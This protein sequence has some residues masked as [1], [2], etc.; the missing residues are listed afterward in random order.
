M[1][2][3]F[4]NTKIFNNIESKLVYGESVGQALSF[5]ATGNAD[6]AVVALA[7]IKGLDYGAYVELDRSL[8]SPILQGAVTIKGA[9]KEADDFIDF[10]KNSEEVKSILI[11]YG[12]YAKAKDK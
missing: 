5:A 4:K 3:L 6:I 1:K 2:L 7:S 8:Y 11:D 10:M 9:P 12:Y